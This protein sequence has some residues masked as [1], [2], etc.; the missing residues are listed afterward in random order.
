VSTQSSHPLLR[1]TMAALGLATLMLAMV[2]VMTYTADRRK[3]STNVELPAT[4]VL[5]VVGDNRLSAGTFVIADN[6]RTWFVAPNR[7]VLRDGVN[8]STVSTAAGA[9]DPGATALG[10][11]TVLDLD[12]DQ[13]WQ[14]TRMGLAAFIDSIGG[15]RI[16]PDADIILERPAK[17]GSVVLSKEQPVF[18]DGVYASVYA[19][20]LDAHGEIVPTRFAAV[21]SAV[22][23]HTDAAHLAQVFV[24]MGNSSRSSMP[25]D[26]LIAFFENSQQ[27][28]EVQTPR[29][30][31]LPTIVGRVSG[32]EGLYLTAQARSILLTAGAHARISD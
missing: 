20:S 27:V 29:F 6:G 13:D 18:L 12:F 4:V 5:Q 1:R 28:W 14:L 22:M 25:S 32:T 21:W 8:Q 31:V 24:A 19:T 15:V 11:G 9:L 3:G 2:T 7:T 17:T 30:R 16:T 26:E 10:L 23:A